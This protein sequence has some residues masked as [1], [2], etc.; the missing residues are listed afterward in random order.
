LKVVWGRRLVHDLDL[1]ALLR[2]LAENDGSDLHL[3]VGSPPLIR[4]DGDL[5]R[6]EGPRLTPQ[7]T[8]LLAQSIM[9]PDRRGWLEQKKETDFALSVP[10]VGRFRANVFYQRGSITL[11]LRRVRV[12]SQSFEDLGLPPVVRQLADAPRGL[13]LVTGP[14][15]AG[16]TTTLAAM[17]D[18]INA[19]RA[20]HIV[21]IEEPIEVLHPDRV[22]TVN[23]REIGMDTDSYE[24][25]MRAVVR[26]DPDV[27]LIG[28]MRDPETV[29]AA[30]AAG[31]TGH[32]V[33]STLHTTNAVETMNRVVD[34]FPPYQQHQVRV[35]M[36]SVIRGVVCMRLVPK[37]GGGRI[38]AVEVMVNNGRIADRI[39]D[40]VRTNE[41]H[42]IIAEGDYYGMQTFDQSLLGLVRQG[43][44]TIDDAL[45]ASSQPHDFLL[46]L[47]QAGLRTTDRSPAA[48]S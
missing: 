45:H 5:Q 15:G 4:V 12:G 38:P 47:E 18:H 1:A 44:I 39:V 32:L 42:E 35:T 30:L 6:L 46:M 29:W 14:T 19:N 24:A 36:A 25:A 26:Q 7:D 33:L 22:A 31:E 8:Q 17:I 13:I 9:P 11:V 20:C 2:T 16:K 40:S 28:E 23:Q 10:G 3:K 41:I 34:F 27:I 21:T 43:L 37:A 48:A